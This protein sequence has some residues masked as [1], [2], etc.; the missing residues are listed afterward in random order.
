M[1]T[2]AAIALIGA[3][4]LACKGADV[5]RVDGQA[6]DIAC[7]LLGITISPTNAVAHVGD[8]LRV[9]A[10]FSDCPGPSKVHSYRWST[11][12]A[13]VATV[14]SLGLVRAQAR[15]VVTIV[16][17]LVDAPDVKGAMVLSVD[18]PPP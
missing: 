17:A 11:T 15:G 3:A 8:T 6:T 10:S 1:K 16:A 12:N 9:R 7:V 14:D 18:P 13:S 2:S 4:L 5:S